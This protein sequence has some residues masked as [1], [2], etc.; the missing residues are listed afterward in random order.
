MPFPLENNLKFRCFITKCI[1]PTN[2]VNASCWCSHQCFVL[3]VTRTCQD[4]SRGGFTACSGAVQWAG[5]AWDAGCTDYSMY[6][7]SLLLLAPAHTVE[8]R[9]LCVKI[10]TTAA[11]NFRELTVRTAQ[12]WWLSIPWASMEPGH[13]RSP[14]ATPLFPRLCSRSSGDILLHR[15]AFIFENFIQTRF[16]GSRMSC[17]T[18]KSRC[19]CRNPVWR[20]L[21]P[22]LLLLGR[23]LLQKGNQTELLMVVRSQKFPLYRGAFGTC[24]FPSLI[25]TTSI[26]KPTKYK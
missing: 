22:H 25:R 3:S 9:K 24:L 16:C 26:R 11:A 13:P 14:T 8:L 23:A 6:S 19:W 17:S 21:A 10:P 15:E 12:Q 20:H 18:P 2:M 4:T 5:S 7:R 1:I